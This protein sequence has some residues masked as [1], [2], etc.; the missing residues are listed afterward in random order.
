MLAM[1]E[2]EHQFNL[3]LYT[4]QKYVTC[5]FTFKTDRGGCDEQVADIKCYARCTS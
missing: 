3:S 4:R 1:R 2:G 5:A